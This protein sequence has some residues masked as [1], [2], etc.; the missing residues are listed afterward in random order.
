MF[1]HLV[2]L[3]YIRSKLV[4]HSTSQN[5]ELVRIQK[6]QYKLKQLAKGQLNF[7][8]IWDK[9]VF[10]NV[11]SMFG[12]RLRLITSGGAPIATNVMNFSRVAY[13]CLLF[14]G[15]VRTDDVCKI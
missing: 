8:T 5:S 4:H 14:E 15:Y 1:E 9:T 2:L 10:K 7:N 12:G 6:F 13:G 3:N 11:R